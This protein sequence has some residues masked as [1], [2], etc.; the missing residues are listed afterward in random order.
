MG[1][2]EILVL[3]DIKAEFLTLSII[4]GPDN[5]LLSEAALYIVEHL[6]A[7]LVSA[8]WKLLALLSLKL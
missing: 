3:H 8:L 7:S 5:S 2:L 6:V 4:E 1:T